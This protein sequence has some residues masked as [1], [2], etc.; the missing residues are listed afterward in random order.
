MGPGVGVGVGGGVGGAGVGVGVS[1]GWLEV[2]AV[3]GERPTKRCSRRGH[4]H[5]SLEWN[6]DLK[7][8]HFPT[9]IPLSGGRPDQKIELILARL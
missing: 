8:S 3:D 6:L 1:G 2:V 5:L 7:A 4:H 9:G